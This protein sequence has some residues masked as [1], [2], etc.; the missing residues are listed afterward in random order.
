MMS[1]Y[2]ILNEFDKQIT[3]PKGVRVELMSHQKT[4]IQKMLEIEES[5]EINVDIKTDKN[6]KLNGDV[7][8]KNF[9]INTNVAILGDKV[10]AGKTL[11]ISSLLS[12]RKN[13]KLKEINY[14][15]SSNFVIKYKSEGL[16]LKSNLVI[17][18]HKLIPQWSENFSKN[19]SN[20]SVFT[21]STNKDIDY[22]VKT[23]VLN[24]K[25]IRNESCFFQYEEIIP[26]RINSYDVILIGETMYRRFY[27]T[28]KKYIWNRIII[29]E[30]D[31]IKLPKDMGCLYKF[32]WLVTGT[33]TGL[34]YTDKSFVTKI[35]NQ[36][37]QS[38]K[39]N[40]YF[41][42][43]NDEK[44]I[45]QSIVLP[46]PKRLKIKCITPRELDI[47]K[48]VIPPSVLQMINAG[49]SEQAIKALNCNVDTNENILQVVT[50]NILDSIKNKQIE[51]EAEIRKVYHPSQQKEH[52]S[53]IKFIENQINKLEEKYND[54]KKKI[55]EL[56]DSHCPVCMGE[57]TNPIITECCKS[58]FCFDCLAISLGEL[59][60]NKCPNCRQTISQ[61][62]IH[63]I[64]D[65]S[66]I[67]EEQEK[68]KINANKYELK[69]KMDVLVDLIEAKPDGSF[70]VFANYA[71]TFTKIEQ[72]LKQLGITYHI[73]KGVAS[74]VAKNID[75]FREKKVRVLMLNA[76]FFGAGM[77]L[78]MTTDLVIFHRFKQEMEEQ[79][80]G[81]AQRLGRKTALNVY[82]LL[83]EN[84][85]NDIVNNF[86]FDDQ[87]SVHYLDWLESN[88]SE[89][90]N[91]NK[92]VDADDEDNEIF[93]IKM[94]NSDEEEM[95]NNLN[96]F[97]NSNTNINSN[98]KTT[99]LKELED[100]DEEYIEC[101]GSTT[102]H[103]KDIEDPEEYINSVRK[104]IFIKPNNK[105]N[106]T[107][108][109]EDIEINFDEFD[110]IC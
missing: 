13:L 58:C 71:E 18:P 50:K 52:E 66:T 57:F 63:V 76:Q 87:G 106:N 33:P 81:R 53:R 9:K 22:L 93:T 107:N 2:N 42:F 74:V 91:L 49:N 94:L 31:S 109:Q 7:S 92:L 39:L 72:R 59:K 32:M 101:K 75:D 99:R 78:Q 45:E 83:H 68:S 20:L 43:K 46:N 56:N 69:D 14:G 73:L 3:Q 61:S 12:I 90:T 4:M 47:I 24:D 40:D 54:I 77:N 79:I 16:E 60:S 29:D 88:N 86:K 38:E 104:D 100:L 82:Y 103:I 67:E 37:S 26:E 17:I 105:S 34:F 8:I 44:F 85:S 35:F 110:I 65:K 96:N 19:I 15:V 98:N 11:M 62:T 64:A 89:I 23:V 97:G 1:N 27:M 30:A 6:I 51:L 36:N 41:V 84:E 102:T 55:Y 5:G 70:M 21:I 80:I 28:C 95:Y 10:G 48:D 108:K 25:N